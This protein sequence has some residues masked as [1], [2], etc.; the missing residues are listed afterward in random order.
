MNSLFQLYMKKTL[1]FLHL[2]LIAGSLLA[3]DSL[4]KNTKVDDNFS[5]SLPDNI[6][7]IDTVAIKEGQKTRIKLL[8]G[9]IGSDK[10][11]LIVTPEKMGI[12]ADNPES[13]EEA[14][15]GISKGVMNS[16]S[17]Q[18]LQCIFKDTVV[19]RIRCIK[20]TAY[21][22]VKDKPLMFYYLFLFNDKSYSV[23]YIMSPQTSG[24]TVNQNIIRL[25]SSITFNK[26]TIIEQRFSSKAESSGYKI[27]Y[28]I[29]RIL[30]FLLIAAGVFFLIK[31]LARKK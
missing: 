14:L 25:L 27:G 30:G 4:W 20:A 12:N 19:D 15:D 31:Y 9:N 28:L 3:Q 16:L 1:L 7:T 2:L 29:G 22:E 11:L 5:I 6:S 26:E 23:G 8:N 17:K 10:I 24:G 13:F 18:G 21:R